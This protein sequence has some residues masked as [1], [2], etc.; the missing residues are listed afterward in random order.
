MASTFDSNAEL[1]EDIR[2]RLLDELSDLPEEITPPPTRTFDPNV[3]FHL[4]SIYDHSIYE[5]LSKVIQKLLP[6]QAA[7]ERLLDLLCQVGSMFA[8]SIGRKV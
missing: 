5:A 7:L 3:T 2:Q 4:T 6:C 8:V 1:L